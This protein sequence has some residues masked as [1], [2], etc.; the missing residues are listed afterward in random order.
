[1][2]PDEVLE[3]YCRPFAWGDA[4]CC[5][6]ACDVFAGW[7][8]LDPMAPLRGL[9]STEAGAMALIREWGGWRRMTARLA[10]LAGLRAGMGEA[11]ELGLIR[12]GDGRG[13]GL[14][15][16]LGGG[17]WAGRIDGGV[18]AVEGALA[19]WAR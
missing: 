10:D 2:I 3:V 14:A 6:S 18:Q 4:D 12:L 13:M 9:Y 5:T 11:R 7:H 17:W 8:G 19:S 15:V 16:G 1:M